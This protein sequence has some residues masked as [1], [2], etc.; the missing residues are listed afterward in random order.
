MV[1]G[2]GGRGRWCAPAHSHPRPAAILSAGGIVRCR[3]VPT[4]ATSPRINAPP[5]LSDECS[6]P[7]QARRRYLIPDTLP[8]PFFTRA[9]MPAHPTSFSI[10]CP[11]PSSAAQ[12]HP[13]N[14]TPSP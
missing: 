5:S 14:P 7:T 9:C 8:I 2:A 13:P 1:K 4:R 10:P 12:A 3:Q 6:G 11:A